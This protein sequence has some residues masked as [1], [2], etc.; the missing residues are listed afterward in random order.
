MEEGLSQ[1][2][3][4]ANEVQVDEEASEHADIELPEEKEDEPPECEQPGYG[5]RHGPQDGVFKSVA[6][7]GSGSGVVCQLAR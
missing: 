5:S 6:V 3:P 1:R 7:E 2:K 4:R